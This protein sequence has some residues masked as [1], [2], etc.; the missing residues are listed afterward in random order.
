MMN[1]SLARNVL[2]ELG[3][4]LDSEINNHSLEAVDEQNTPWSML[5][6]CFLKDSLEVLLED[7]DGHQRGVSIKLSVGHCTEKLSFKK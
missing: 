7:E 6:S 1:M 4:Y 3:N 2:S 5:S